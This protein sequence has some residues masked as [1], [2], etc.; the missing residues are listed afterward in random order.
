MD[1]QLKTLIDLQGVDTR[2]AAHA[3]TGGLTSPNANSYAGT[4]P[5]GCMYH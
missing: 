1:A 3:W 2:I 4:W 5:L